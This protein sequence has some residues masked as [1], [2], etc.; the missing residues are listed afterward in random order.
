MIKNLLKKY[1]LPSTALKIFNK[2][3][4]QFKALN[5]DGRFLNDAIEKFPCLNDKTTSTPFDAHYI[6]HPAWAARIIKDIS[7]KKHID[8]SST[9]HFCSIL[10]AFIST[11]FYDFR[12]AVLDLDNLLSRAADLT[13]LPFTTNSIES[14]SCMHT[15]EHIGLG[16]DGDLLDPEG[17]LKA[18]NELKR[19]CAVKGNLLVVIPVGKKKIMFN[20]HRIY[21]PV[22]FTNYFDGFKLMEFSLITDDT[23]FIRNA[24]FE[25][26]SEQNYGCGCYWFVKN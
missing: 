5:G 9:L 7:P 18:I 14:L 17:D 11:E 2:E 23:R 1:S 22:E 8:I 16:R 21:A 25:E 26:A 12:P 19:V 15:L 13:N 20:A 3:L 24:S 10:S 4:Q 6:Y